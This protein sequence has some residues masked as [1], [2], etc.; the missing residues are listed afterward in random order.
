MTAFEYGV[1]DFVPKP[2]E[3]KRLADAFDR[4]AG[5]IRVEKPSA[6]YLTGKKYSGFVVIPVDD[7]LYFKASHSYTETVLKSGKTEILDKP[8]NRLIQILPS[9]FFRLHRSY[10]V[11]V[12]EIESFSPVIKGSS[13]AV[14]KNGII[15]PLSRERNKDLRRI[16]GGEK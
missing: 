2:F 4:Y 5:R 7:I 1:L 12:H 15:L 14:L 8:L 11:D 16:L 3:R 9:R 6:R 13:R 10:I